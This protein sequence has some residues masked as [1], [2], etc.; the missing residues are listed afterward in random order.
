MIESEI[1]EFKISSLAL[2]NTCVNERSPSRLDQQ[3]RATQGD[4]E[5]E[6]VDCQ[7]RTS[8]LYNDM[9]ETEIVNKTHQIMQNH[10]PIVIDARTQ[11]KIKADNWYVKKDEE[12]VV[13]KC[14]Q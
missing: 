4:S 10:I 8:G 7:I 11:E 5:D 9:E 13:D 1:Y 6:Q 12:I 2:N 3:D 14:R